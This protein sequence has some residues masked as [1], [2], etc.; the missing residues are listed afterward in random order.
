MYIVL[1]LVVCDVSIAP[2]PPPCPQCHPCRTYMYS[3][4]HITGPPTLQPP[5]L[6]AQPEHISSCTYYIHSPLTLQ[7][8][9]RPPPPPPPRHNQSTSAAESLSIKLLE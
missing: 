7:P 6:P 2:P 3:V 8:P 9:V 1:L 4:L 5:P